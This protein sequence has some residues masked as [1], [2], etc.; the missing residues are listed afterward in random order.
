MCLSRNNIFSALP[1]TIQVWILLM[2][3]F[4]K[5]INKIFLS[6]LF[7]APNM[8]GGGNGD[9]F[10]DYYLLSQKP[11]KDETGFVQRSD[12][13][14]IKIE[15]KIFH[16][17]CSPNTLWNETSCLLL[18]H[19]QQLLQVAISIELNKLKCLIFWHRNSGIHFLATCR[20]QNAWLES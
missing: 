10:S 7:K 5:S 18:S 11:W 3:S 8:A 2:H 16:C 15:G 13:H 1:Q 20:N 12:L 14:Y 9:S 6:L 4:F 17:F 19:V